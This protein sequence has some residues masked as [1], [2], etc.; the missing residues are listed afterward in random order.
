MSLNPHLWEALERHGVTEEHLTLLL[1]LLEV[2]RNGHV[3]WHFVHGNL[4]QCDARLVFPSR[5]AEVA[6]VGEC[7]SHLLDGASVVR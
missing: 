5:P 6:R 1:Q 2:Q 3:A 4:T 7:L